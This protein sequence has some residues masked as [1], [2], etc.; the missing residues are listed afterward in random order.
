MELCAVNVREAD[1]A[2]EVVTTTLCLLDRNSLCLN[3]DDIEA[4][5]DAVALLRP[6]KEA[7]REIS[8]EYLS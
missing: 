8:G 1:Q 3:N 2:Y 4:M 7:K 5:K 6:F